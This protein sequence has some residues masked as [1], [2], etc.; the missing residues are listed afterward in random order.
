MTTMTQPWVTLGSTPETTGITI[1]P[2][3]PDDANLLF[4][5]H[6]RLS[7]ESIYYRYLQYRRPTLVEIATICHLAPERGAGF[8]AT[9]SAEPT[10]IVGVAYYVRE[11]YTPEPTAEPG[12]SGRRSLS[13]TRDRAPPLANLA[14]ISPTGWAA[15]A[16]RL[17]RSAE[18]AAGSAG[19]GR[20]LTLYR[21]CQ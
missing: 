7:P 10:T 9:L 14:A 15:L 1:R 11:T 3:Q 19:A 4:A 12:D 5:M 18:R 13:G 6:Q 21:Q 8:V 17:G 2:M 20:R 16:A